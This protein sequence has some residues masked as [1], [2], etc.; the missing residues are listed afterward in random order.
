M[1]HGDAL[2]VGVGCRLGDAIRDADKSQN[3]R[4]IRREERDQQAEVGKQRGDAGLPEDVFLV[5]GKH[6]RATALNGAMDACFG[7]G[8]EPVDD[9][10]QGRISLRCSRKVA[11]ALRKGILVG[12]RSLRAE[13]EEHS[14]DDDVLRRPKGGAK[15]TR[16]SAEQ[17][18]EGKRKG[19]GFG[20]GLQCYGCA[21]TH[22]CPS[23]GW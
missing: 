11:D 2:P 5:L 18:R 8:F 16:G 1:A 19:K 14:D 20:R 15:E 4:G 7:T 13:S 12:G 10:A 9:N 6:T 22:L 23:V 3:D 21:S 17:G